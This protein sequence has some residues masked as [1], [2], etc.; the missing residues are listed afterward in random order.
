MELVE[1][2][3]R[4]AAHDSTAGQSKS[5]VNAGTLNGVHVVKPQMATELKNK[6]AYTHILFE[7]RSD[8]WRHVFVGYIAISQ[9]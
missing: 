6:G 9:G 8:D 2:P 1:L 3:T 7:C 5:P 4:A